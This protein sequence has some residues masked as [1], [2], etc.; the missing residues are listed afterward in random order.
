MIHQNDLTKSLPLKH[1]KKWNDPKHFGT[2]LDISQDLFVVHC[3]GCGGGTGG[4][5]GS[6]SLQSCDGWDLL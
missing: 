1:G 5:G 6:S 3:G 4:G 2:S